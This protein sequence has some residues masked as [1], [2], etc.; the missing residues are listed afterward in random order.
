MTLPCIRES[1]REKRR[2]VLLNNLEKQFVEEMDLAL[3]KRGVES[4]C[5]IMLWLQHCFY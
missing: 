1:E 4:C 3:G 2:E 5:T